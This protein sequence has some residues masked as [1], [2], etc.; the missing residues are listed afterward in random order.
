M[1]KFNLWFYVV[2]CLVFAPFTAVKADQINSSAGKTRKPGAAVSYNGDMFYVTGEGRGVYRI[3]QD[4]DATYRM[5]EILPRAGSRSG[6]HSFLHV[7]H[8]Y[9]IFNGIYSY[10]PDSDSWYEW[11]V[12]LDVVIQNAFTS[13]P[14][15]YISR[16]RYSEDEIRVV[17][18]SNEIQVFIDAANYQMS[19]AVDYL[20][21]DNEIMVCDGKDGL[22]HLRLDGFDTISLIESVPDN[23]CKRIVQQDDF[24]LTVDGNSLKKYQLMPDKTLSEVS[25]F[26]GA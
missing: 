2:I 6:K 20:V 25:R 26:T 16:D 3:Y 14:L 12:F 22:V 9:L 1:N 11:D 5:T 18:K 24:I 19:D 21:L 17:Y 8:D 7:M 13:E 23:L 4:G 15:I 10:L